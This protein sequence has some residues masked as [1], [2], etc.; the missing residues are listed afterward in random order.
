MNKEEAAKFFGVSEKAMGTFCRVDPFNNHEVEGF[1][2]RK[3][4]KNG[5]SL[6]ITKVNGVEVPSEV[7]WGTPKLA[8]PYRDGTTELMKF[9]DK[10]KSFFIGEKWNG[11]NILFFKYHDHNGKQYVSAK[12]KGTPFVTNSEAGQFLYLTKE[13]LRNKTVLLKITH[14]EWLADTTLQ[15][16]S[17][18]LCG[19]KEPHLV[20]YDFDLELKPLFKVKYNGDILPETYGSVS[21]ISGCMHAP[22]ENGS[23]KTK[24]IHDAING[25]KATSYEANKKYRKERNLTVKYEYNH[26]A[27]EGTVLYVLDENGV[28]LDRT[29][30]KIK[31]PD[32]E[33]VHWARFDETME[34][35]VNEAIQK[36]KE[37]EYEVTE[38]NVREELDMGPKEWGKFGKSVTKYMETLNI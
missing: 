3:R 24:T 20:E 19:K 9:S 37:R 16:I 15:S 11:M 23:D 30:Y 28:T 25:F 2:C 36:C 8:Y 33:E 21:T 26:F 5:G 35:R 18:E 10:A 31:P 13:A 29:M 32:I 38:D 14:N 27:S 4:N 6:V 17:Y 34:A 22:L 12:S 1:I 7:V